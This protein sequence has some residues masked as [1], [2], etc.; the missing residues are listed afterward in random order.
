[1]IVKIL[2]RS[3]PRYTIEMVEYL[4]FFL[5][6]MGNM[7]VQT[8]IMYDR[9]R[10]NQSRH[11]FIVHGEIKNRSFQDEILQS[12]IRSK[13]IGID[14]DAV[15]LPC[16]ETPKKY[17][18]I[19]NPYFLM[20]DSLNNFCN[21][22]E[23]FYKL[24]EDS[25]AALF[26]VFKYEDQLVAKIQKGNHLLL[27]ELNM[28][29]I[30]LETLFNE[31]VI[32]TNAVALAAAGKRQTTLT[33]AEHYC[34]TF[35]DYTCTAIPISTAEDADEAYLLLVTPLSRLNTYQTD[36]LK[37][38][39]YGIK[40]S[41]LLKERNKDL[42]MVTGELI[43]NTEKA[44]KGIAFVDSH[45]V[46]KK[47]NKWLTD[48]LD[49]QEDQIVGKRIDKL[50]PQL[51]KTILALRN[52]N[53]TPSSKEVLHESKI[54]NHTL[55]IEC[56]PFRRTGNFCGMIM[57][58]Y[59]KKQVQ[60]IVSHVTNFSAKYVFEDLIGTSPL[61]INTIKLAENAARS[62][63][64]V[65]IMGESGTGKELFAQ[66]IHNASARR[67]NPFVSIN[68]AAIPKDL[69]VSELFGYT[70]GAFTGAAKG[71]AA[72]KFELANCGTIFL[73][74]IGEMPLDMQAVLLRALEE[75]EILRLGGNKTIPIDVRV[76]AATNRNLWENVVE[77]KFRLDLYFRLNVLTIEIESLKERPEDI[78]LLA[79]YFLEK[80]CRLLQKDIKSVSAKAR[81][82]L[83]SY[84]WPGNV[85]ELRNTIERAVNI[86]NSLEIRIED[87]PKRILAATSD[88]AILGKAEIDTQKLV[89]EVV[90][91]YENYQKLL[92]QDLAKKYNGNKSLIA[93]EL[94]I[95]RPT[96]YKKLKEFKLDI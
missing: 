3:I 22:L 30:G 84:S 91:N 62:E 35:L 14:P 31:E 93:K 20:I 85:R 92:I 17:E 60:K 53:A 70:E 11:D 49:V 25:Y 44:F 23:S 36:V 13:N 75:K 16:P 68:C 51:E 69:I 7:G 82:A 66:A 4:N 58:F 78:E 43:N 57:F 94:C 74:E 52:N 61:F 89:L 72:G 19:L 1:M 81:A 48:F 88:F 64:N 18:N 34:Q 42:M 83:K 96:L 27:T 41:V 65:L 95:T 47:I 28:K 26:Y 45:F 76:I 29:G 9:E 38:L 63:S 67:N 54:E 87:L 86:S 77:K 39:A 73:D 71:G 21:E 8:M 90:H 15:L 24:L 32:G 80:Y 79:D 40:T 37:C 2:T 33:G 55:V 56:R 6:K 50:F 12:W 5:E 46:F 10:I 59:D